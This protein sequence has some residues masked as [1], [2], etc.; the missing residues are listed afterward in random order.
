MRETLRVLLEGGRQ[1]SRPLRRK[2]R[3]ELAG[4]RGRHYKSPGED[5]KSLEK[6][7]LQ[8]LKSCS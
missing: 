2:R 8:V 4:S 6:T 5:P 7:A 1:G 3:F